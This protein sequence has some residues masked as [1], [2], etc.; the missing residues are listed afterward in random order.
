M[1]WHGMVKVASRMA[2]C[3]HGHPNTHMHV[4]TPRPHTVQDL[5]NWHQPLS[6]HPLS[7]VQRRH[8][9]VLF[10][11][12]LGWRGPVD[13]RCRHTG[14]IEPLLVAADV[15]TFLDSKQHN[16]QG[17]SCGEKGCIL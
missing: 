4:H 1:A 11:Q 15:P 12:L 2:G 14:G 17:V 5:C 9:P 16:T 8:V 13:V 3:A 10:V 7:T 6:A